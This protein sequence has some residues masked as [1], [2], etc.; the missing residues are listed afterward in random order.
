MD[1]YH[2]DHE[3]EKEADE[4]EDADENA[5]GGKTYKTNF[6]CGKNN[7]NFRPVHI[8]NFP[9]FCSLIIREKN[10]GNLCLHILSNV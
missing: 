5:A 7:G 6:N 8:L 2:Y 4:K 10:N 1:N 3:F 9:L